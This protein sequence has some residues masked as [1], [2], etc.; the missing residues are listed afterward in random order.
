LGCSVSFLVKYIE[1]LWIKGMSW[2]NRGRGSGK[3]EIDHKIPCCSFDMSDPKQQKDCF[4]YSNLQPLWY[5]DDLLKSKTDTYMCKKMRRNK[6][7]DAQRQ[8]D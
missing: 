2:E 3:W 1:G 5:E 6:V 4:H 8:I 7:L